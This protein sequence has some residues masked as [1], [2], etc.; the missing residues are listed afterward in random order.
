M[1]ARHHGNLRL[2]DPFARAQAMHLAPCRVGDRS[3]F[4][5]NMHEHCSKENAKV[6]SA[7]I[8]QVPQQSGGD[9]GSRGLGST[10]LCR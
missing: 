10:H 4:L 7:I 9:C 1:V 6:H 8:D 3:E 2:L 5:D